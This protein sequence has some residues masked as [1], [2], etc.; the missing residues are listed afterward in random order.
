M[1][2]SI[3]WTYNHPKASILSMSAEFCMSP[4]FVKRKTIFLPNI[5]GVYVFVNKLH[6][7]LYISLVFLL[8]NWLLPR[9]SSV[10]LFFWEDRERKKKRQFERFLRDFSFPTKDPMG[11][12]SFDWIE[13]KAKIR[14]TNAKAN[15]NTSGQT[16]ELLFCAIIL[17]LA[18]QHQMNNKSNAEFSMD[19]FESA[20]K[21]WWH[22]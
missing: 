7:F 1:K 17:L 2:K 8:K 10:V 16:I 20:S 21:G 4:H 15:E 22:H 14:R 9:R 6:P 5:C 18:R 19:P 12:G 11:F 3:Q 13:L